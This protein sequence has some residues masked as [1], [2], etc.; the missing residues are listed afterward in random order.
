M[1]RETRL[2][3]I[4]QHTL[5]GLKCGTKYSVRVTATDSIGT[6]APA[7]IDVSTLGGRK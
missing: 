1:A 2:P 5:T 6:S 3:G 7:H 4:Q